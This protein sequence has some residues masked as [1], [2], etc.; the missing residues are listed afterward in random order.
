MNFGYAS[1]TETGKTI[2]L[3]K[4][5]E[6]ERFSYQLYDFVCTGFNTI[7]NYAGKN[8]LEIGCGRGG[9]LGYIMKKFNPSSALGIDYSITNT[10][11]CKR[12]Y[13]MP[14]LTFSWGDGEKLPI[15]NES[16]DIVICI[17]TSHCFGNLRLVLSEVQRILKKDG[18]FFLADFVCAVDLNDYEENFNGFISLKEKKDIS[19]NVLAALRLDSE[20]RAE[21]IDKKASFMFKKI[22]KRFAAIQGSV[23]Y[24]Q[25]EAGDTLYMGYHFTNN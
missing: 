13:S 7:S 6:V 21:T 1:D 9:G 14:G 10:N 8:V 22:L 15:K 24:N 4:K 18:S 19:E 12:N 16:V 25:L 3:D 11:F 20:R 2:D 17:E 23:V 5:F